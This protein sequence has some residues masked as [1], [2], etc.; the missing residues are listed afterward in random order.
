M[1]DTDE[2]L[3]QLSPAKVR[4]L[5][6]NIGL[7]DLR[8]GLLY[9]SASNSASKAFTDVLRQVVDEQ[10]RKVAAARPE[11]ESRDRV[12]LKSPIGKVVWTA[13]ADGP[14]VDDEQAFGRWVVQNYPSEVTVKIVLQDPRDLMLPD[15]NNGDESVELR[16]AGGYKHEQV[17]FRPIPHTVEF[18][19]RGQWRQKFLD[20][21]DMVDGAVVDR[22]SGEVV[23]G[24]VVGPRSGGLR[25][26]PAAD[27]KDRAVYAF[28]R[29]ALADALKQLPA[30]PQ[31]DP[32]VVAA[33]QN[34]VTAV[35]GDNDP[36]A[37]LS[38]DVIPEFVDIGVEGDGAYSLTA[39]VGMEP[40]QDEAQVIEMDSRRPGVTMECANCSEPVH[41]AA[42]R[43]A[44]KD[45][46][47]GASRSGGCKVNGCSC[48]RFKA[49]Q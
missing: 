22:G 2:D 49:V 13:V 11:G 36:L 3:D 44:I 12:E 29:M 42:K 39:E 5:L 32:A 40:G 19:V 38:D 16:M 37:G 14:V 34:L 48:K 41:Q 47:G 7:A 15:G 8:D 24:M 21:L 9:I 35:L 31:P 23:P 18:D 28:R 43:D 27:T 26:Y 17:D 20:Q 1:T 10:C 45:A 33:H 46:H 25:S 6:S 4:E 30:A